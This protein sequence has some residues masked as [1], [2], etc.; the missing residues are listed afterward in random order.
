MAKKRALISVY[1]KTGV[2]EFGKGLVDLGFEI[3]SS[4]GTHRH[5][6][7]NGVPVQDLAGVTG[8]KDLLGGR[9]KTL[10]PLVYAGILS[11]DTAED[12]K[13]LSKLGMVPFTVIAVNLYPFHKTVADPQVTMETAMEQVDIGGVSLLRAGAKAH[14]RC[15][16]VCD[17][18]DYT[19]VLE[20]LSSDAD[21]ESLR[22]ELAIKAFG[23]TAAYDADIAN[24]MERYYHRQELPIYFVA[25]YRQ[26]SSLRYGENPHQRAALYLPLNGVSGPVANGRQLSGRDI[27]YN[28]YCDL[29]AAYTL[30]QEFDKPCAVIAKHANPCGC[31][32][33]DDPV[34]ALEKARAGDP[35][36]AFGGIIA[37]N[38]EI[39]DKMAQ[40]IVG[41]KG[42]F[43]ALVAPQITDEALSMMRGRRGWGEKF[44]IV[45][46]SRSD[47][48]DFSLRWINGGLLLSDVD[49]TVVDWD[50]LQ[51]VTK[52]KVSDAQMA[53]LVFAFTIVKHIKSNA[54]AIV[55][56][57]MLIGM[58]AGQPNRILSV[59]LALQNAAEHHGGVEGAVLASDG[60]FPMA[61]AP[62]LA[63]Q[64]GIKAIIQP[65]GSVKDEEVIK[66]M[67]EH[68]VAMVFANLRH[69]RH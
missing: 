51:V 36:S 2:V 47:E 1:D 25:G 21:G 39:D 61:D 32:V 29:D 11:R 27:S 13:E 60:F 34:K 10:H 42:F 15:F 55:R 48:E 12:K 56:Q 37:T 30:V 16:V 31:A 20:A 69:F 41:P 19:R 67:D 54:I 58:G 3:I 53:D 33:D 45:A 23:H 22:R 35:V 38:S 68:K 4:G 44:I 63:V 24:F 57:G 52:L 64:A 5:L 17:V 62:T 9:V 49:G 66:A 18:Q 50:K 14:H 40:A 8:F 65:G 28:N 46:A 59:Q 7:D 43:E 6:K 26:R